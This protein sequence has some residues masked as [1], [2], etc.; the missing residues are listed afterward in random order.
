MKTNSIYFL[1]TTYPWVGPV[2]WPSF[3]I[4]AENVTLAMAV[5]SDM[6]QFRLAIA[7]ELFDVRQ[8]NLQPVHVEDVY[9]ANQL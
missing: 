4:F 5:E 3:T 9:F 2:L 8:P 7:C 6:F 1:N